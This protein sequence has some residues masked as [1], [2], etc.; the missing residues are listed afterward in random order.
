LDYAHGYPLTLLRDDGTKRD[1]FGEGSSSGA[2]DIVYWQELAQQARARGVRT[3]AEVSAN[4]GV[5]HNERTYLCRMRAW[6]EA[7]EQAKA[8]AQDHHGSNR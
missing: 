5:R 6:H 7:A 1:V 3:V 2:D 4:Q 8:H